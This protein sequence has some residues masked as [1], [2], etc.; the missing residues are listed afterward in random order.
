MQHREITAELVA[1]VG[2]RVDDHADPETIAAELGIT[3]YVARLISDNRHLPPCACQ[4]RYQS[5]R[6]PQDR[7]DAATIRMVQRMLE[8]GILPQVQIGREVGVSEKTVSDIAAGRRKAV[9]TERP[10]LCRGEQFVRKT[11]RCRRCGAKI[12]V[13]PCRACRAEFEKCFAPVTSHA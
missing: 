5:P 3:P 4:S 9:T 11:V 13:V 7:Q 8:V 12:S 10:A 1:E 6:D 2:R